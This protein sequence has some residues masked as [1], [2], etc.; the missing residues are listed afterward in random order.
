MMEGTLE[1]KH[2]LQAGGKKANCRSWNSF[3]TVLM[4]QT[5]CFYQD[6]KDTLKSSAVAFPLNISGAVCTLDKEYT[7]KDNCFTLQMKD[8]SKYLLRATTEPLM[9]EW[10]IKLQQ[11]SGVLDVDYF[12]SASQA[13]QEKTCSVR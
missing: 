7:K 3:H 12:Q 5:L 10:V 1:R 8:G 4:R 2:L 9:K 6:K 11:N 13:A